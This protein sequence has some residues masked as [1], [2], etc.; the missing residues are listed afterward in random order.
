MQL[1]LPFLKG[2]IIIYVEKDLSDVLSIPT[3]PTREWENQLLLALRTGEAHTVQK[4]ADEYGAH[5]D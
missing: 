3:Q 2:L 4:L 5:L 1:P